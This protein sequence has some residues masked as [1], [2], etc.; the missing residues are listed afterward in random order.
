MGTYT[1]HVVSALFSGSRH[2]LRSKCSSSFVN[3]GPSLFSP[4][5]LPLVRS[6]SSTPLLRLYTPNTL[7][8]D[9][10][11][12]AQD[13]VRVQFGPAV[14]KFKERMGKV[15][16]G[17]IS[18]T[19]ETM[20]FTEDLKHMI[21]LAETAEDADVVCEMVRLFYKQNQSLRFGGFVFGPVVMRMFY[22]LEMPQKAYELILDKELDGF[23]NQIVSYNVC[24][25]ALYKAGMYKEV[26]D[27]FDDIRMKEFCRER[28]PKSPTN[29]AFAAAYKLGTP[30]AF[31]KVKDWFVE[32]HKA[33]SPL[34]RKAHGIAALF[35]IQQGEPM[36]GVE[37]ARVGSVWSVVSCRIAGFADADRTQ[38]ALN[39]LS[40][41]L[42][43]SSTVKVI[44]ARDAMEKLKASVER[45]NDEQA[46][47]NYQKA[48]EFIAKQ[49]NVSAD[50]ETLE[51]M[52]LR[53]ID[54]FSREDRR[55]M[56]QDDVGTPYRDGPGVNRRFGGQDNRVNRWGGSMRE[57]YEERNRGFGGGYMGDERRGGGY[58]REGGYMGGQRGGYGGSRYGGGREDEDYDFQDRNR[59]RSRGY[60]GG[61]GGWQRRP[62]LVD[63]DE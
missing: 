19:K 44:I 47:E 56:D 24:M 58:R 34:L 61:G 60:G 15:I 22:G 63:M 40:R 57:G 39:E 2:S 7:G 28:F 33:D 27:L 17:E 8:M 45:S 42:E 35:A 10:F 51:E 13:G 18:E 4:T 53:P 50:S 12:I 11:K 59:G 26:L 30:E 21:Y 31:Q 49:S 48:L 6:I 25:D 62:G 9:G 41:V 29:L 43:R 55:T 54:A 52:V 20:V 38:E 37:F 3:G 32:A 1:R 23:F 46:K 14:E 16:A 5:V 36:V